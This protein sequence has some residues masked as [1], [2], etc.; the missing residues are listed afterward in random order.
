MPNLVIPVGIPGSGKSTWGKTMFGHGKYSLISSDEI[1]RELWGSLKAAH[2]VTPEIKKERNGE[3]WDRFYRRIEDNLT[4]RVD[5]YA[6]GTNLR[7]SARGRLLEIGERTNS[8]THVIVFNN[9]AQAWDRNVLRDEDLVVPHDVMKGFV[10][11]FNKAYEDLTKIPHHYA[12]IT[13]IKKLR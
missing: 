1:R 8:E 12:S 11:L 6:D 9:V 10:R 13:I 4:H 5:T 2:D 3:V 7:Q